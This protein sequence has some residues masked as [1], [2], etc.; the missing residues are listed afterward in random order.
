MT[1]WGEPDAPDWAG[2]MTFTCSMEVEREFI[3]PGLKRLMK[4]LFS[5]VEDPWKASR[6]ELE[7]YKSLLR[8]RESQIAALK[9]ELS[10]IDEFTMTC[11]WEGEADAYIW[12]G[13]IEWDCPRCGEHHA[14]DVPDD[15]EPDPDR[16]HDERRE[17]DI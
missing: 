4:T 10:I 9:R 11:G 12:H 5:P 14:D 16:Y 17:R 13:K 1:Y 8:A 15:E 2:R 3:T 7:E 6:T